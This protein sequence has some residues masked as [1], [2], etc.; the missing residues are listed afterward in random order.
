[1]GV[2]LATPGADV[3]CEAAISRGG[4][5]SQLS[6]PPFPRLV[7]YC[8][9][10][11]LCWLKHGHIFPPGLLVLLTPALSKLVF[12]SL[13]LAKASYAVELISGLHVL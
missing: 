2:G 12:Q 11:Q 9:N 4:G 13:L 5:P 3:R 8:R 7:S 10:E 6:R 1:M